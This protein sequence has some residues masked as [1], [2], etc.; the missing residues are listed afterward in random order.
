MFTEGV[1]D[2][3]AKYFSGHYLA[4]LRLA[5]SKGDDTILKSAQ[6]GHQLLDL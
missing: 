1:A 5:L 2:K 4:A 3:L 6:F